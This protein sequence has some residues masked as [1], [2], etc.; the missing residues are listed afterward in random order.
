VFFYVIQWLV[1]GRRGEAKTV[2]APPEGDG[3]PAA[4]PVSE[5]AV[6]QGPQH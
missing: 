5:T 3:V 6:R 4:L 2:L 1:G